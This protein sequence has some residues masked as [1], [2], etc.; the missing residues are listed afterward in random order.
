MTL[1]FINKHIYWCMEPVWYQPDFDYKFKTHVNQLLANNSADDFEQSVEISKDLLVAIYEAVSKQ[2]EGVAAAIN[3][4]IKELLLPQLLLLSNNDDNNPNEAYSA[5]IAIAQLDA[6]DTAAREA[7][8]E[9]S[10]NNILN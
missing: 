8:I 5:I 3:K 6:S 2:P 4:E 10:K 1:K 7:I 9:K